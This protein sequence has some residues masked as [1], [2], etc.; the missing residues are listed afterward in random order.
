MPACLFI[1]RLYKK[2]N[3][4][5]CS[6]E[7]RRRGAPWGG[8]REGRSLVT[9]QLPPGFGLLKQ[10][11][12]PGETL[13]SG[14]LESLLPR[15]GWDLATLCRSQM[16]SGL[17]SA[18]LGWGRDIH[19]QGLR[20]RGKRGGQRGLRERKSGRCERRCLQALGSE[21]WVLTAP[22][23]LGR[24]H[25]I[26]CCRPALS[27]GCL[28]DIARTPHLPHPSERHRGPPGDQLQALPSPSPH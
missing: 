17:C 28:E 9:T 18:A 7:D 13:G 4:L 10:E 19:A 2:P 24:R 6:Q 5:L 22:T 21:R 3:A 23:W 26:S 16:H 12:G 15:N 1:Y 20:R 25:C 8:G 11:L 14:C 27:R